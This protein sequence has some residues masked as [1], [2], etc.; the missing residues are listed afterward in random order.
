LV[1]VVSVVDASVRLREIEV[2]VRRARQV[3]DALLDHC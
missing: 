3:L 2:E 1:R